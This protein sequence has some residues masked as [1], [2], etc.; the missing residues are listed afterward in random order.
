MTAEQKHEIEKILQEL[1]AKDRRG[2][3]AGMIGGLVVGLVLGLILFFKFGAFGL[4][5]AVFGGAFIWMLVYAII[6][7]GTKKRF[8]REIVPAVL[9]SLLGQDVTY[10]PERGYDFKTLKSL[11]FFPCTS[12]KGEDLLSGTYQNVSF[13]SGDIWMYHTQSNGKTTTTVTDFRG[14]MWM[15]SLNKDIKGRIDLLEKGYHYRRRLSG[16]EKIEFE[17]IDFNDSFKSYASDDHEAFYIV[18]PRVIEALKRNLTAIEGHIMYSV[19]PDRLFLVVATTTDTHF[20]F[21]PSRMNNIDE[22]I[23]EIA[24]DIDPIF[25]TI[26]A[27]NLDEDIYRAEN[28]DE[29]DV[30]S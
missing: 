24:G 5:F 7:A 18:T 23:G 20:E 10:E 8:K 9:R 4:V 15:F 25:R 12:Y 21:K 6:N 29:S 3:T 16:M 27:F 28:A 22:L 1:R 30:T 14:T 13:M 11:G 17:D 19:Q 26:D 2:K